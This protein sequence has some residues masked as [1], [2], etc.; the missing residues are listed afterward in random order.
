MKYVK[1]RRT[2]S[3]SFQGAGCD[4]LFLFSDSASFAKC[5]KKSRHNDVS[6]VNEPSF[7][8]EWKVQPF[9]PQFRMELEFADVPANEKIILTHVKTNVNLNLEK[10]YTIK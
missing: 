10:E 2:F 9:N 1:N 6:L 3:S 4:P 8:T 5:A 7:L